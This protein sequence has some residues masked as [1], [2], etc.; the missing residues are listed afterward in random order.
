MPCASMLQGQ[1]QY[2]DVSMLFNFIDVDTIKKKKIFPLYLV[3]AQAKVSPPEMPQPPPAWLPLLCVCL[4]VSLPSLPYSPNLPGGGDGRAG[5]RRRGQDW[6]R[7][8]GQ[9][10]RGG[11][12]AGRAQGRSRPAAGRGARRLERP[13]PRTLQT[14]SA[15]GDQAAGRALGAAS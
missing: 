11:A 1:Y 5:G 14:C 9:G 15:G 12:K 2:S 13:R 4:T 10:R 3:H 7:Q 6:V 8:L